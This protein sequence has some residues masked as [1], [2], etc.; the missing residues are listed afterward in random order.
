MRGFLF[1]LE[2]SENCY[3]FKKIIYFYLSPHIT[4][5]F[6]ISELVYVTVTKEY[7]VNSTYF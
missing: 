6:D 3:I 5:M 2:A 7:I 1:R 4:I